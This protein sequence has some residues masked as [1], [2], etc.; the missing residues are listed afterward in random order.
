MCNSLKIPQLGAGRGTVAE[1]E[2]PN[3][4]KNEKYGTSLLLALTHMNFFLVDLAYPLLL[5]LLLLLIVK[6][7]MGL[8]AILV[9]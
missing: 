5:L 1:K 3:R 4:G 7:K 2:V 9:S 8:G 6:K